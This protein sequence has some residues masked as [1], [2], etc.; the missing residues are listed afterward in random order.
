MK[1]YVKT[2]FIAPSL[3]FF[4]ILL[5]SGCS[6]VPGKQLV[7]KPAPVTIFSMLDGDARA[8]SQYQGRPVVIMF[9]ASWCKRSQPILERLNKFARTRKDIT[10][11]AVSIDKNEDEAK[12]RERIT[13]TQLGALQHSF[14]G[15]DIG[16]QPYIAFD[17]DI[18]PYIAIINAAG[19]VT[20]TATSDEVVYEVFNNG[21]QPR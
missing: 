15:N 1:T 16:D 2:A 7:G 6:S 20:H 12:V 19:V 17:G 14:S 18:V 11:I 10:F 21:Q 13:Y 9:W 8:L 4:L 5:L 3:I